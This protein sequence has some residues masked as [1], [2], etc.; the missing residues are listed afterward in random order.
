MVLYT[1]LVTDRVSEIGFLDSVHT[2]LELGQNMDFL[3]QIENNLSSILIPGEDA[4]SKVKS[5]LL[6]YLPIL[7]ISC[8]PG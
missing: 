7:Y 2:F 3:R 6:I 1:L 4:Q 8:F 5:R